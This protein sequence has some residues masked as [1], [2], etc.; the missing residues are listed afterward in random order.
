MSLYSYD[1]LIEETRKLAAEFRRSTGTMLPVSGEI[2]RHDVSRHLDLEL[3]KDQ[4]AGFDAIGRNARQGLRVQ[5]KS[6]VVGDHV[7]PGHRLGQLNPDG[8]WD[9]V[10]LSLM[11]EEFE[12]MEMYEAT[13][14]EIIEA[15]QE[16]NSNRKKRGAI[17]VAKFRIIG[18]LVWTRETGVEH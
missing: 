15:I 10:I 11:N 3:N 16:I 9:L 8:H 1:K 18:K 4:A 7:K 5:I 6:R 14:E 12:P 13:R 2:A 17:S